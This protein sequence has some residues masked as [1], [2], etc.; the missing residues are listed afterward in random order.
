V[1]HVQQCAALQKVAELMSCSGSETYS[2]EEAMEWTVQDYIDH[3]RKLVER[4]RDLCT[5][6]LRDPNSG[7]LQALEELM[8]KQVSLPHHF[9]NS[10][11]GAYR[12][13]PLFFEFFEGCAPAFLRGAGVK[14]QQGRWLILLFKIM[15]WL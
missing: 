11:Q 1:K 9:S 13:D 10:C 12:L 3:F 6:T 5:Q 15:I 7:A 2:L 4:E 14:S 8:L